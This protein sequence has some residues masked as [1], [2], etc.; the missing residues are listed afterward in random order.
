MNKYAILDKEGTLYR[1]GIAETTTFQQIRDNLGE[2]LSIDK[3]ATL[4]VNNI[5]IDEVTPLSFYSED[6]DVLITSFSSVT[7]I[8]LNFS[9]NSERFS[10]NVAQGCSFYSILHFLKCKYHLE[11]ASL[12]ELASPD[13]KVDLYS[14]VSCTPSD[15]PSYQLSASPVVPSSCSLSLRTLDRWSSAV[16]DASIKPLYITYPLSVMELKKQALNCLEMQLPS[17]SQYYLVYHSC[18]LSERAEFQP[19]LTGPIL[20]HFSLSE[21]F[22]TS[23]RLFNIQPLGMMANQTPL[24]VHTN[25]CDSFSPFH[26]QAR[27][28]LEFVYSTESPAGA[29]IEALQA[30]ILDRCEQITITSNQSTPLSCLI[31]HQCLQ[32]IHILGFKSI[33][34]HYRYIHYAGLPKFSDAL[35][36][37]PLPHLKSFFLDVEMKDWQK[38]YVLS[39]VFS[40]SYGGSDSGRP[41]LSTSELVDDIQNCSPRSEETE[42]ASPPPEFDSS[43]PYQIK[44]ILDTNDLK[45][46]LRAIILKKLQQINRVQVY[47]QQIDYYKCNYYQTRSSLASIQYQ[48]EDLQASYSSLL[49]EVQQDTYTEDEQISPISFRPSS[50]IQ[51]EDIQQLKNEK[52]QLL[53]QLNDLNRL[54]DDQR[55]QLCANSQSLAMKDR[56]IKAL[57]RSL[58][59]LE[60]HSKKERNLS[61]RNV[62]IVKNNL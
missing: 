59:I 40:S 12:S 31:D 54:L 26:P 5:Q 18:L 15:M 38:V 25:Q 10:L 21:R 7:L 22:P 44:T 19:S 39:S 51:S 16:A 17:L 9:Y 48:Y 2:A 52:Q 37:H 49:S 60:T 41:S 32:G 50:S 55:K 4:L 35:Q 14:R 8:K 3:D 33:S 47:Q 13:R 62:I 6:S 27:Y 42:L 58:K 29:L 1:T 28:S 45:S 11:S 34:I 23:L 30:G 46:K 43:I 36:S 53:T 20:Y 57:E 61:F 56:L 24:D